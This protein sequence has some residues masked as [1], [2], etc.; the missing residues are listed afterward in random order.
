MKA[1][2]WSLWADLLGLLQFIER[3]N[4]GQPGSGA[5]RGY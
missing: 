5:P 1:A 4:R 3:L 2:N